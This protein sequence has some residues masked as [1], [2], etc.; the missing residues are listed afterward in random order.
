MNERDVEVV[1][2]VISK[3]LSRAVVNLLRDLIKVEDI[4][5]SHVVFVH[6]CLSPTLILCLNH[7]MK[8]I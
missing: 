3:P 5:L 6:H 4:S 1:M 8:K 7:K 2:C